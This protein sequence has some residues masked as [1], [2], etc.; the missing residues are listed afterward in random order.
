MAGMGHAKLG[1]YPGDIVTNAVA[2]TVAAGNVWMAIQGAWSTTVFATLTIIE[3]SI[4]GTIASTT[5]VAGAVI[6]GAFTNFTLTSGAVIAYRGAA[7]SS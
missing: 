2:Q 6:Y 5:L 7:K 3:G 4:A 1:R